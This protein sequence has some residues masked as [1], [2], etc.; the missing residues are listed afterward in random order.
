LSSCVITCHPEIKKR[1][2]IQH[3]ANSQKTNTHSMSKE[4]TLA[5]P[6]IFPSI[7]NPPDSYTYTRRHTCTC[8]VIILTSLT[9]HGSAGTRTSPAHGKITFPLK[10]HGLFSQNSSRITSTCSISTFALHFF[11]RSLSRCVRLC[12]LG[13]P[14]DVVPA[15]QPPSSVAGLLVV[16]EGCYL[17]GRS[18]FEGRR[19][20]DVLLKR[21]CLG[22]RGGG[23]GG[24]R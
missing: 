17:R 19:G 20:L 18:D 13:R 1:K 5:H 22:K 21:A 4:A 23:S 11:L 24:V 12:W 3:L 2:D 14:S 9:L 8:I 10:I 15:A 6:C 16:L 7:H